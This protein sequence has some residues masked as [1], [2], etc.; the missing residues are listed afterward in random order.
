MQLLRVFC[1]VVQ[2]DFKVIIESDIVVVEEP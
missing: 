2:D 1:V